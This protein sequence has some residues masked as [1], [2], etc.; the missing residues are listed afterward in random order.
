[1]KR[2]IKALAHTILFICLLA[3]VSLIGV[4]WP[5]IGIT[6]IIVSAFI[7]LFISFRNDIKP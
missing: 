3:G 2:N 1:M 6:I 5:I 7:L 4:T